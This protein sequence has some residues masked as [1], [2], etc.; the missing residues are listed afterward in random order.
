[1]KTLHC[2]V[3]RAELENPISGRTYWHIREYDICEDCKDSIELKLRR[4]LRSRLPY[5]QDWYENEFIG[6][7]QRGITA[8][9][10]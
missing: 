9:R 1:M 4:L 3:C 5:S 8:R 10:P 2:D 7:I 6:L